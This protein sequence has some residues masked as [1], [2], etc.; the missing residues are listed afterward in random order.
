MSTQYVTRAQLEAV[1]GVSTVN[2]AEEGAGLSVEAVI[3]SQCALADA[4]VSKQ[5]SLPPSAAAIE[6][7]SPIVIEMV[8]VTLYASSGS[9]AIQKR[10]ET[11]M[12]LLRDIGSG[13]CELFRD[14]TPDNP[15]TP[16]DEGAEAAFG[17]NKRLASRLALGMLGQ[18]EGNGTW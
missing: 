9:E 14:I 18:G 6:Q 2:Q 15:D 10:R 17:S 4:Y 12:Q 5:V 13:K 7:V 3:S 1:L 11:A 8:Y 16:E